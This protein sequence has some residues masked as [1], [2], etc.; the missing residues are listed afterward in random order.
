MAQKKMTAEE[1]AIADATAKIEAKY[2]RLA[3]QRLNAINSAV[4]PDT[5]VLGMTDDEFDA[6][7]LPIMQEK[8]PEAYNAF[9]KEK[10]RKAKRAEKA[11]E[12]RRAK[13]RE[14]GNGL[15]DDDLLA[16]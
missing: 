4:W 9:M 7:L 3:K 6:W 12:R 10:N 14:L 13:K 5:D 8:N 15:N 2:A 11:R 16:K 1:K